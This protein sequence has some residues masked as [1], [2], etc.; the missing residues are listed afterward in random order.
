MNKNSTEWIV[1]G[2]PGVLIEE[3]Q[4]AGGG[5]EGA[6]VVATVARPA[7]GEIDAERWDGLA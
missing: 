4:A 3:G 1:V 6:A 7:E 2:W 5:R